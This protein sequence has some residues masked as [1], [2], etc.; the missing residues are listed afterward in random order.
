METQTI[1]LYG[2]LLVGGWFV[3]KWIKESMTPV[4]EPA[5]EETEE[6]KEAHTDTGQPQL[7]NNWGTIPVIGTDRG[8]MGGQAVGQNVNYTYPVGQQGNNGED[9]V[10]SDWTAY[11]YTLMTTEPIFGS[12]YFGRAVGA[13]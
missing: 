8:L 9:T 10:R 7:V 11:S 4:E 1:L 13:N 12:N 2:G 5:D 3:G 6:T